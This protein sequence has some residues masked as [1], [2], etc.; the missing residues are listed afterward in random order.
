MPEALAVPGTAH[1]P[2]LP[3]A[4]LCQLQQE[5]LHLHPWQL[6]TIRID[7]FIVQSIYCKVLHLPLGISL[8]VLC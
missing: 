1:L 6:T 7:Q 3:L 5:F 8:V 4:T 2:G